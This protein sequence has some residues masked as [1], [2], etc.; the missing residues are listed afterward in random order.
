MSKSNLI[1]TT[2]ITLEDCVFYTVQD[3]PGLSEP[4][5]GE[6]D[7][8]KNIDKY[9]GNVD[10]KDK[11]VLELGPASG[12][13][14]FE[15]ENRGGEITSIE[16][17]LEEDMWDVVPNCTHDWKNEEIDHRENNLKFVKMIIGSLIKHLIH[18][19]DIQ[20]DCL[21]HMQSHL[22]LVQYLLSHHLQKHL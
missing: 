17:S 11:T 5:K 1:D 4:T 8:R 18:R 7:L 2:N 21:S 15:I 3:I 20:I 14:T 22:H 16:L 13:L 19:Q 9:L 10:F 12:C 6:W